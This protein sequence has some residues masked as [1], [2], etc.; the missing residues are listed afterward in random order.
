[1]LLRF[2]KVGIILR[3]WL[4]GR[5]WGDASLIWPTLVLFWIVSA[6]ALWLV[7]HDAPNS[8]IRTFPEAM[9]TAFLTASTLGFGTRGTP[10]TVDGQ[11]ISGLTVF[12]A[13]GL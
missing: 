6:L 7:E 11:I 9:T 1:R 12:F 13:L 4:T 8:T 5:G 3:R 10:V 2:M